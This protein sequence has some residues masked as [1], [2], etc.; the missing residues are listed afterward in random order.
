MYYLA[1]LIRFGDQVQCVGGR[2]NHR[3]GDNA[4][5]DP[6]RGPGIFL[7]RGRDCGGPSRTVSENAGHPQGR[8]RGAVGVECVNAVVHRSHVHHVVQAKPRNVHLWK[9]E[10][11]RD[12]E[13]IDGERR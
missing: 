6:A 8:R 5:L 11:L 12:D 1:V 13:T 3:G 10:R 7:Y 4:Q 9:I 2:V